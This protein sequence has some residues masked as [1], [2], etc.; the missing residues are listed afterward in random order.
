MRNMVCGESQ[1]SLEANNSKMQI[2]KNTTL[3][4]SIAEK[5]GNFGTTIHN[6]A[7]QA[8]GLNYIYMARMVHKDHLKRAV[9]GIRSLGIRGCGVS[10]PHKTE[11]LQYLDEI[12]AHAQKIGAVN[13]IVNDNGNLIGYNTD[14]D[15][16][17]RAIQESGID[18]EGKVTYIVG[19]GGVARAIISTLQDFGAEIYVINRTLSK[20]EAIAEEF[21]ITHHGGDQYSIGGE[22]LVNATSLGMTP[23]ERG[24]P[25]SKKTIGNFNA[26]LDV[27]TKPPETR[28]MQLAKEEGLSVI[29]GHRMALYQ[30]AKQFELYTGKD[31]PL[32]TMEQSMKKLLG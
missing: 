30:A 8:L 22:L 32:D 27:V 13:T 10:M 11:V 21:G 14:Y 19:A 18:L 17:R 4:I 1:K 2:D 31:A 25:A 24:I 16:A 29:P 5:P 6:A 26:V 9:E 28:F 23:N 3:C 15:G 7:F 12:E 20:A